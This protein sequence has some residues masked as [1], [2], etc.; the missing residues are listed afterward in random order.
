MDRLLTVRDVQDRLSVSRSMA[1]KLVY[2]GQ[3][4]YVKIGRCV[5]VRESDVAALIGKCR[6]PFM[7]R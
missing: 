2:S 3:L 5:R 7:L 1:W 6:S 4:P